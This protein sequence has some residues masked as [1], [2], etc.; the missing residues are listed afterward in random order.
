MKNKFRL[1][2]AMTAL[3]V[4]GGALWLRDASDADE[5]QR[6]ALLAQRREAL[7]GA[8]NQAPGSAPGGVPSGWKAADAK[9]KAAAQKVI[10]DQ[11]AAFRKDDYQSAARWQS[12][13]LRENFP[14][15]EAFRSAITQN[16][17][18]FAHS[19]SVRYGRAVMTPDKAHLQI[20]TFVTGQDDVE[21][22]ALYVMVREEGAY[23]VESVLPVQENAP[24]A[25]PVAP[26]I[27]V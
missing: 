23:R 14:S 6:A 19:K 17:P 26:G 9:E 2:L 4:I 15:L 27:T 11:L 20:Q 1:L 24:D 22:R 25:A 8:P 5:N 16:Y 7:R 18:Q 3:L 21:V 12:R 13:G 10:S